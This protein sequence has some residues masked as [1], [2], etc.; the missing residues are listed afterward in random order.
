M[1]LAG[2]LL[3]VKFYPNNVSWFYI[4][5][6]AHTNSFG[7][8]TL[9]LQYN[10]K[11]ARIYV[12]QYVY[13]VLWE[14]SAVLPYKETPLYRRPAPQMDVDLFDGHPLSTVS[15]WHDLLALESRSL[16]TDWSADITHHFSSQFALILILK[17]HI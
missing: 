17:I 16:R 7:T 14:L 1:Y 6:I 2:L 3:E 12:C 4:T 13:M 8:T 5:I 10:A 15:E 11:M 9:R